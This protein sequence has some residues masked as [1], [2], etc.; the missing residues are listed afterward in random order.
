[1]TNPKSRLS[2][3]RRWALVKETRVMM[4]MKKEKL[5]ESGLSH[6]CHGV[7]NDRSCNFLASNLENNILNFILYWSL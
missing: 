3:S 4:E 6:T 1:L 5:I 2:W 7:P